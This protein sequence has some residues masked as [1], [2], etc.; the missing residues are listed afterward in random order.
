M[1]SI[2]GVP[3]VLP[4]F[5]TSLRPHQEQAISEVANHFETRNVVFLDAPTGAGKTII[6]EAARQ[7]MATRGFHKGL[8]V[9]TT[10]S[11]QEQFLHDFPNARLIMGRANYPT[12]DYHD[13]FNDFGNRH[14]DASMC[15]KKR[16]PLD[17][18]TMP[19]CD[20]CY[21]MTPDLKLDESN[22]ANQP[23]HV[24]HC[25][26]CHPHQWCPYTQAKMA[27]LANPLVVANTAYFLTEANGPAAFGYNPDTQKP[28]FGFVVVDEA[29]TL[30]SV[31]MSYIELSLSKRALKRLSLDLPEYKTKP[32]SW[33]QWAERSQEKIVKRYDDASKLL[34]T[35]TREPPPTD[36]HKEVDSLE[37][38]LS[39]FTKVLHA[40][41]LEPDNW[42]YDGYDKGD[43]LLKPVTVTSHTRDILW[44]HGYK[45]LLMSATM[46]SP[47][48]MAED[49]GL[50]PSEWESVI[51]DS[52]FPVERRPVWVMPRAN[53]T[54]KTKDREWPKM[55]KALTEVLDR[56]RAERILVHT[57]SYA[58]TEFLTAELKRTEHRTRLLSY[59]NAR[60]RDGVLESYRNKPDAVLLAP[61]FDRGI[62][63]P[64]D[65]CRV[66]VITK[67]P[68]PNTMDKQVE[69]RLYGTRTGQGWYAT[70][71]VRS[72]VQM[73]GR[74]MRHEMDACVS[75]ILDAQFRTNIWGNALARNRLPR[76]WTA[77]LHWETPKRH[78]G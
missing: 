47:H 26:Y 63:L 45:F 65:M 64:D 6:G 52:N 57:H 15:T 77:A 68:Y 12:H 56:H 24:S 9:C 14:V 20:Q 29:D 27:A 36:L 40:L 71:T 28:K 75:Y 39:Q 32:E 2:E 51:V 30:E 35:Y 8:Y 43:V 74:G 37:R 38:Y 34:D 16:F 11:L 5:V 46:I 69:K 41:K 22:F 59:T 49:L 33:L 61:S 18:D 72:L 7:V 13:R 42:V 53:M 44:K 54:H 17:E 73:T 31:L 67:V 25:H 78:S 55:A 62:D 66:I 1:F 21:E 19:I 60:Q 4:S 76:W 48:Q 58:L 23:S 50:Q 3:L 10:K 70:E